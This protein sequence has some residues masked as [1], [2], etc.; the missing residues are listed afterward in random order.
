MRKIRFSPCFALIAVFA[1]LVC[2]YRT[3]LGAAVALIVHEL[4]HYFVALRRGFSPEKITLSPFGAT[5]AYDDG[6]PEFDE[7]A[8]TVAGPAVNALFCLFLAALWWFFP[9][10]YNFTKTIFTANFALAAFSLLP[11]FPFDG[12]RICLALTKNKL[13]TLKISRIIGFVLSAAAFITGVVMLCLGYGFTLIFSAIV[14]LWSNVFDAPKEKYKLIFS[15]TGITKTVYERKN[16]CVNGKTTLAELVRFLSKNGFNC[17]LTLINGKT[18]TLIPDETT[19]K[20]FY[21]DRSLT[22]NNALKLLK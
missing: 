16:I 12:G 2:G 9:S 22:L 3:L 14:I 11:V 19:E 13:R 10:F 20:L 15:A 1:G 6:L 8:V 18:E 5:M 21:L 17:K 7:F 4:G